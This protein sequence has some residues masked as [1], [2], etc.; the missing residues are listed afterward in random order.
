MLTSQ[1]RLIQESQQSL[2]PTQLDELTQ[3]SGK[4][5]NS[6]PGAMPY[7]LRLHKEGQVSS[8]VK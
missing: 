8:K 7:V 5:Y 4:T 3:V 6:S 2:L 1:P